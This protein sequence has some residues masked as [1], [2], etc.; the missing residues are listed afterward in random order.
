MTG[1]PR[2]TASSA[3][4]EAVYAEQRERALAFA[5]QRREDRRRRLRRRLEETLPESYSTARPEHVACK[6]WLGSYLAGERRNLVMAGSTGT[7]KTTNAYGLYRELMERGVSCA[8]D[9]MG[10]HLRR[11]KAC[12][13]TGKSEDEVI[14][15]LSG[16]PVLFVDDLGKESATPWAVERIFDVLDARTAHARPTVATTNVSSGALKARYGEPGEAIMSRLLGGADVAVF[17]GADRRF[18]P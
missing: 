13:S 12:Y 6:R 17:D 11:I 10:G 9:T 15:W 1:L 5:E 18:E 3:L 8:F 7:G 2:N 16:V 4:L 14:D